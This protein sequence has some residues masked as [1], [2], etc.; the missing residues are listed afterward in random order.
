MSL[1]KDGEPQG[2]AGIL[3]VRDDAVRQ[4]AR[5]GVDGAMSGAA[6]LDGETVEVCWRSGSRTR[7]AWAELR[8]H[9]GLRE[10]PAPGVAFA[11]EGEIG[12]LIASATPCAGLTFREPHS[13]V[14]SIGVLTAEGLRPT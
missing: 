11:C 2:Y 3:F 7:I 5:E 9:A 6:L 12:L 10:L 1:F 14:H 4:L 8:E 13:V